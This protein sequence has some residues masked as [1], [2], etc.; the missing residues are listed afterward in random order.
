M[1]EGK[2]PEHPEKASVDELHS[3]LMSASASGGTR[4]CKV[5]GELGRV[6][7]STDGPSQALRPVVAEVMAFTVAPEL[8]QRIPASKDWVMCWCPV[9]IC[10]ATPGWCPVYICSATPGW[11]PVYICS[12][13]LMPCLYLSVVPLLADALS[14]SVVP[15]LADAL[16]IS[17]VPLLADALSISVVPL[18]CPVY[19]CS[20]TLMPC[21][22]L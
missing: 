4:V 19:I 8:V 6:T 21:L 18:W 12:A 22:Y 11:C 5:D 13:T 20:A 10:S 14:I 1:K 16:S 7:V 15:L 17:V 2:K 3:S 9:Y